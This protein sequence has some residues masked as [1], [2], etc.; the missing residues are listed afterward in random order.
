MSA[1][2]RYGAR[3][4]TAKVSSSPSTV[5]RRG[6]FGRKI[7]PCVMNDGLERSGSVGLFRK[8]TRLLDAGERHQDLAG[9]SWGWRLRPPEL[10][11]RNGADS[12]SLAFVLGKAWV[13]L[14]LLGVD[15]V[16]FSA[17]QFVDGH[18]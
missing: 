7:D 3:A 8:S 18:S 2:N 12:S 10:E 16:A 1:V 5:S 6:A 14:R 11:H 17:G 13:A 9:R 15:A 4:L